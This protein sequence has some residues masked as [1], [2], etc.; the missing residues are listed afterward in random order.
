MA[1]LRGASTPAARLEEQ[2]HE[3][4]AFWVARLRSDSCTDAER[5]EFALWLSARPQHRAAMDAMLDLWE[6]LAV[7][8]FMPE[9]GAAPVTPK[10]RWP[11][12][13]LRR[14]DW[15]RMGLG[16]AAAAAAL[17]VAVLLPNGSLNTPQPTVYQTAVGERQQ[18][19]LA[20]GST[21]TLNTDSKISVTLD[22]RQRRVVL[23]RGE[24]YFEVARREPPFV[25]DLGSAEVWVMGTAFNILLQGGHGQITVTEGVVRVTEKGQPANRVAVSR[26][27]YANQSIGSDQ[28]GLTPVALTDGTAEMAWTSGKLVA[29]A[30]PLAELVLELGRYHALEILIGEPDLAQTTVSGV[31]ELHDPDTI[32]RALEQSFGIHAMT[33][34]D[35]SILLLRAA[36]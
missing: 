1:I 12:H 6:D 29:E 3:R 23:S 15:M 25:V 11:S 27:L 5:G 33:L 22:H 36:R 10:R 24:A 17:Y 21:I 31:F 26:L 18:V 16:L 28:R 19:P 30:M 34:E 4:A 7:L 35:D 8:E 20:D 14:R 13:Q 2:I 32:L 9:P